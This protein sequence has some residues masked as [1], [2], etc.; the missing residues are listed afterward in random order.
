MG[1]DPDEDRLPAH[2]TRTSSGSGVAPP[3][4]DVEPDPAESRAASEPREPQPPAEAEPEPAAPDEVDSERP[5]PVS[6]GNGSLAS[7]RPSLASRL[8][9]LLLGGDDREQEPGLCRVLCT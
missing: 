9:P 4:T 1:A 6:S 7:T 3:P 8:L 5:D 2:G